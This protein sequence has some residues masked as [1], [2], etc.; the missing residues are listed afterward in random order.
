MLICVTIASM[1]W[2]KIRSLFLWVRTLLCFIGCG[3]LIVV[4]SSFFSIPTLHP[5]IKKSC[6]CLLWA[7]GQ[8][9]KLQGTWPKISKARIYMF[10]HTSMLDTFIAIALIE[11]WVGAVGKKEQFR[12][13]I[14]GSILRKWGAIPLDRQNLNKAKDQINGVLPFLRRGNGLLIAPEGTRSTTK[15]LLPLKKGPFHLALQS[16]A[17]IIPFVIIGAFESKNK[18]SWLL[19]PNQILVEIKPIITTDKHDTHEEIRS[20]TARALSHKENASK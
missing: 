3:T 14:W 18:G 4:L 6:R 7:A 8:R 15:E 11:E 20:R 13:P 9:I 10:N 5:L 19:S 2:K 17:T 12:I 1:L 16:R